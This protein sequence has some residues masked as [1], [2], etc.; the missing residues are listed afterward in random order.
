M[1]C[2]ADPAMKRAGRRGGNG[3]IGEGAGKQRST[4]NWPHTIDTTLVGK[5]LRESSIF[6][7]LFDKPLYAHFESLNAEASKRH[8]A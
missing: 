1:P 6:K 3:I 5:V 2:G 7:N 4:P 8:E